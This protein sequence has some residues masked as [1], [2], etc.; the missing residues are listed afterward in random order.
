MTTGHSK[1]NDNSKGPKQRS[2]GKSRIDARKTS[3]VG[4][5][6]INQILLDAFPCVALIV[7]P[8]TREIVASNRS[9]TQ[10]GAFPGQT[11]FGTW[12]KRD[13]P[14]PFCLAPQ[15]WE[16]GQTQHLEV[17]FQGVYWS[18][19]W[20]PINE[21][22]YLHF[23]FDITERKKTEFALRESEEKYRLLF[24][25]TQNG[26]V[27][28]R[29]VSDEMGT[30]EDFVYLETNEAFEGLI[31]LKLAEVIGRKSS[32][33]K[34]DIR[35]TNPEFF[36]VASRV[37][38]TGSTE[39]FE[40][41]VER[42]KVWLSVTIYSPKL[43]YFA[44]IFENI[45]EQ[46]QTT[47]KLQEYSKG[48]ESTV[49]E[50]TKQLTET[51]ERLLKAE[52]FAAIGE[53]AGMVGHDLRNPLTSI[54]NAVYYL[55]RKRGISMDAKEKSMFDVVDKSVD[56]ANKIINNLL[57]YSREITLEIEE[58]T[59]KSLIDYVLLM[60][61]KPDRIKIHDQTQDYPTLWVDSNKMERV[62]INLINNA[63]DA[64]PEGGTLVVSSNQVGENVEFTFTDTGTGMS[65]QTKSKIFMPLFTT[66]AQGMGFGLAICKRIVEAHGGKISVESTLG[67]GTEFTVALPMEQEL[68]VK[69][70]KN[71]GEIEIGEAQRTG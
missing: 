19:H 26:F 48:L 67:K 69:T 37:S 23:A 50:R 10:L 64:M 1:K 6:P 12:A 16:T 61:Q 58:C 39:R 62:F 45:T 71:L 9:A 56:H 63:I 21:G 41:F 29:I 17:E 2:N 40:I 5:T 53:L 33:V 34:M 13:S 31:G 47:Q 8:K 22:L 65:E 55:N 66:K 30:P 3:F 32:E 20:V 57:E 15:V 28:C 43:G 24:A 25:N 46:K 14:C 60:L 44:A 59:P 54:K 7:R 4:K 49:A 18:A 68:G 11:C 27:Y 35:A 36:G 52:R 38:S 42:Q 51:S 70:E